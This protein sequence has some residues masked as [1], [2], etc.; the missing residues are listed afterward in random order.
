MSELLSIIRERRSI[1]KYLDRPVSGDDLQQILEALRWAPS[2]AN[3]QCWEVV[4]VRDPEVRDRLQDTVPAKGNPA[5]KAV[6]MAP[7]VL[8]MCAKKQ[9]SGF[10]KGSELTHFGDWMMYDLGLATQNLCLMAHSLGLGTVIVGVFDHAGAARILDVPRGFEPVTLIP[11]G[12]PAKTGGA[13]NRKEVSDFIHLN[14][15]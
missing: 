12:Y 6:G 15:W 14:G 1:R 8:V 7:V 11:L 10:Y 9:V 13:P 2:W 4:V 3:T 5:F